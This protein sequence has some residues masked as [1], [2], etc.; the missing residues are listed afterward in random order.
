MRKKIYVVDLTKEEH[1]SLLNQSGR[2]SFRMLEHCC[3]TVVFSTMAAEAAIY[4]YATEKM[5]ASF[6]KKYL[7][8]LDLVSK[9]V[10]IPQMATGREFP[11]DKKAGQVGRVGQE[12]E[13]LAAKFGW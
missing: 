1:T 6:V 3:I 12:L 5:S 2:L 4:D 11:R 10:V 8:R 9:W 13:K 7:D